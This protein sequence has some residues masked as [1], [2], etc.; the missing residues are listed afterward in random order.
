MLSTKTRIGILFL[1][2]GIFL[3]AFGINQLLVA[4]NSALN[5][6]NIS[7]YQTSTTITYTWENGT[8]GESDTLS[9]TINAGDTSTYST[10][11]ATVGETEIDYMV[12]Y[13]SGEFIK[14]GEKSGN[15]TLFWIPVHNPMISFWAFMQFENTSVID[16]IGLLGP[17]NASYVLV[18]GEEKVYWDT[19]QG[20]DGA[21]FS[22]VIRLYDENNTKVA[23]GLMD[24]TCGFLETLNGGATQGS[25]TIV[26]PGL[27]LVSRN[28][29]N[30]LLWTPILA[31]I[32]CV[33][34][35]LLMKKR[36]IAKD[37][38]EEVMLL[39]GVAISVDMVDIIVDVWFYSWFG[40]TWMLLMHLGFFILYSLI[41]LRLGYGIKW[42]FPAF[43]EVTFVFVM[44]WFVGDFYVPHITAFM[45]MLVSYLAMLYRSGFPKRDKRDKLSIIF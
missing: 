13:D 40:M 15:Y 21:Q 36:G 20:L 31:G 44:N 22:F 8:L 42:A 23:E 11:E 17:I 41:C 3:G 4:T 19:P 12:D 6:T 45:G 14:N 25:L 18:I 24:S 7:L 39:F 10:V 38:K 37:I 27:F 2:M 30:L 29:Y 35:Y 33:I 5:P 32:S 1:G 34:I 9:M 16:P 26:S 43:I 28:R